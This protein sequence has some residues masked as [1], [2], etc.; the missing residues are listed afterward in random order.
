[1]AK[2][3]WIEGSFTNK[4]GITIVHEF[5]IYFW[6]LVVGLQGNRREKTHM[7]SALKGHK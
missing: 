7:V 3:E 2:A 5:N 6:G 4:E 1:M